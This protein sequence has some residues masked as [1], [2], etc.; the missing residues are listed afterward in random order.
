MGVDERFVG[1]TRRE[2]KWEEMGVEPAV[3]RHDQRPHNTYI[4]PC[5]YTSSSILIP[6]FTPY[7]PLILAIYLVS[8]VAGLYVLH[9][10]L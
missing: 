5:I 1:S 6:H 8:I 3:S 10:A 9:D 7:L 4:T 2:S